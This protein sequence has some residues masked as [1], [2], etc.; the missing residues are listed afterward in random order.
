MS[1]EGE[2]GW[3]GFSP[4]GI[5]GVRKGETD[6]LLLLAPPRFENLMTSHAQPMRFNDFANFL[7][8]VFLLKQTSRKMSYMLLLDKPVVEVVR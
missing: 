8:L 3:G 4:I 5:W 6:I 2:G 1:L 7:E